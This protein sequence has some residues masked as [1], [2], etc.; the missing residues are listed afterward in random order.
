VGL[1]RSLAVAYGG[2]GVRAVGVSP[3]LIRNEVTSEGPAIAA[4][5]AGTGRIGQS[6][7]VNFRSGTPEELAEVVCFAASD[8]AAFVNGANIAADGG[9]TAF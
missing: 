2:L 3:G 8:Q 6:H 9:W 4:A 5:H 1:T 7:A